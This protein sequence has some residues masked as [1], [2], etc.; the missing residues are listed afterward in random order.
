MRQG[1]APS[2]EKLLVS[3]GFQ[4]IPA[5][6]AKQQA[7]LASMTPY[8]IQ[9]RNK[10]GASYYVYPDPKQNCLYMG[11]PTQYAAYK[12]MATAQNIATDDLMIASEDEAESGGWWD[13]WGPAWQPVP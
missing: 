11:G 3:A 7:S 12:K 5:K 4:A 1:E 13:Y 9:M 8:K 2:K 10:G 6:T